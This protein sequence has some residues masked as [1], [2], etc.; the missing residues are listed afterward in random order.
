MPTHLQTAVY[1]ANL[2]LVNAGLITLT[3]GNASGID[4]ATNTVAIKPSGVPYDKLTPD[5]IV[6]LNLHDGS[7]QLPAQIAANLKPSSDTPTHLHLYRTFP[8]IGGITHTHSTYAT[9]FAQAHRDI[10]CLGTTH[11]D[12]FFGTIPVTRPL[13]P[14]EIASD[15]ELNT[16]KVITE[17]FTNKNLDPDDIPAVLIASHG[18]FA[19]GKNPHKALDNAI[20]LEAVAHMQLHTEL[21]NPNIKPVPQALLTKHHK[22]KHGPNAYYGQK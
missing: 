12:H 1:L 15:Y 20:A 17:T 19:W 21:L 16:G 22:R 11:A 14:D 3:W 13:T 2:G 7:L 6:L 4:R 5:D 8:N 18:P 9:I 10:P